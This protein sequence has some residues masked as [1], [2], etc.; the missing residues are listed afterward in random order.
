[1]IEEPVLDLESAAAVALD[2][3]DVAVGDSADL[4]AALTERANPEPVPQFEPKLAGRLFGRPILLN[5]DREARKSGVGRTILEIDHPRAVGQ[6]PNLQ[7]PSGRLDIQ[8]AQSLPPGAAV[9]EL[10]A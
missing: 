7:D 1:M 6:F 8:L 2:A 5:V 9:E 4:R 10:P 3:K